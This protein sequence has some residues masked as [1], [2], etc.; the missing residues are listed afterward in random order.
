MNIYDISRE[1]GVSIAT[2]SRVLNNNPHVSEETRRRV[3]SVMEAHSYV[4]NAFARGLGLNTMQ[5]IGL[6]CP[7]AADSYLAAALA[8]L[9]HSF[10]TRGYNCQLVCTGREHAERERGVE[11]L[12]LRHMDGLVLMG[13]T[14]V[15]ETD[16][17]NAYIREAAA[18]APVVLLN[19]AYPSP[20]VYGVLCDDTQST[21]DAVTWLIQ[22]GRRRILYVYH[23]MND[24]GK[25]KLAGY[26]E[27]LR[28]AGLPLEEELLCFVPREEA[29]VPHVRGRLLAL[30]E[31][32]LR[33]D[34]VMAS[35]DVVAVGALK[36]AHAAGI[37]VPKELA[38]IGYNDSDLCVCCEPELSSVDGRLSPICTQIVETML[39][40]LQGREMPQRI[41][42]S[43]NLVLRGTTPAR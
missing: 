30:R 42:F 26:Q 32:G 6:L 5:T 28:R 34:A 19:A 24:S 18:Q 9:E 23:S 16:E 37:S 33:F 17:G 2:V 20:N 13:S 39:G 12:R 1:A 10:R 35:N 4:P 22:A 14:F 8:D 41:V 31:K 25:R 15:E 29:D 38:V 27:A 43:G 11:L 40:V 36:Y 3:L 21:R 7:D